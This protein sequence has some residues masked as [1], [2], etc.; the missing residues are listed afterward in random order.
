MSGDRDRG[1]KGGE[2]DAR[3]EREREGISGAWACGMCVFVCE[4]GRG[5]GRYVGVHAQCACVSPG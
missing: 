4:W 1:G 3:G 2:G 5:R